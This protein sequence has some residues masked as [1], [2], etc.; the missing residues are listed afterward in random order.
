MRQC[1]HLL[2]AAAMCTEQPIH[3]T[4]EFGAGVFND[5]AFHSFEA[6]PTHER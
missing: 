2:R 5:T 6:E 1:E 3:D 4:E